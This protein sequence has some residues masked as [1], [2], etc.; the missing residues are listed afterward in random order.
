MFDRTFVIN[1]DRRPDRWEQF[2]QRLRER[3]DGGWPFASPERHPAIDG[4]ACEIPA[5]F[6]GPVGAWGCLQT[7]LRLWKRQIAEGWD[8]ILILEDDAVF[9][10]DAMQVMQETMEAMPPEWEQIY[11]G[12]QHFHTD[13]MPPES[14][15]H[16][17]L[18][19]CRCVNRTHAY[20][21]RLSFTAAITDYIEHS[22]WPSNYALHH[23]DYRLGDLHDS[24]RVYAPWRFC[25]GQ[26]RGISDVKI[27]QRRRPH[28][29]VEHW[30]NNFPIV[31]PV[32]AGV[33]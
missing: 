18:V 25:I 20:A 6:R 21:I 5:Y 17:K 14:L 8:S 33:M 29:V 2:Q 23:V 11:F 26:A 31:D 3:F 24:H 7:H 28:Y 22:P 12:G 16:Q 4:E 13:Q 10:R 19:R 27:A 30:W 15:I 9:S 32:T 1:L